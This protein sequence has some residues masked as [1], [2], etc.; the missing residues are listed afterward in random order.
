MKAIC[1]AFNNQTAESY[2]DIAPWWDE[3]DLTEN[4]T[5]LSPMQTN[6]K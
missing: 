6:K 3:Q 1:W 4:Q 5:I 2:S